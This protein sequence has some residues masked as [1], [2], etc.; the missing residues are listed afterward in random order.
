[1]AIQLMQGD[2][3][4]LMKSLP[5]KSIDLIFT[6]GFQDELRTI[7]YSIAEKSNGKSSPL[8]SCRTMCICLFLFRPRLHPAKSLRLSKDNPDGCF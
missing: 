5:D 4:E 7:L 8:K 3:L 1:M 2:C 6:D